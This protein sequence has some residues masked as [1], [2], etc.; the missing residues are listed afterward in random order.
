MRAGRLCAW[1]RSRTQA[2]RRPADDVVHPFLLHGSGCHRA[3]A[4]LTRRPPTFARLSQPRRGENRSGTRDRSAVMSES[5]A[6][7]LRTVLLCRD[8]ADQ[9]YLA[10]ELARAGLLDAVVVESRGDARRAKLLKTFRTA[11]LWAVPLKA[12]DVLALVLYGNWSEK[13]LAQRL[14]VSDYP[15]GIPR[16][17]I[18]DANDPAGVEALTELRPRC[19]RGA[20]NRH[21]PR[22]RVGH[23]D[24][25]RAECPRR[26]AA[27]YRNVYSD[28]WPLATG[29][30]EGVG[31]TIFHLDPGVD[32]G[33]IA[34]AAN[35]PMLPWL[36]FADIKVENSR[37]RARLTIAALEQANDGT[38]PRVPQGVEG[39]RTWYAPSAA[40]LARGLWRIRRNR[41]RATRA[42]ARTPQTAAA[43]RSAS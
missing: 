26:Q 12:L 27:Q 10:A 29:D 31:S 20:R 3:G 22:S 2:S 34:L 23:P 37:L 21:P 43:R 14:G 35:V 18:V 6:T 19:P 9:R 39:A 7:R 32:T 5:R 11:R 8:G 1:L 17:D 16:I 24:E 4:D 33:D 28:F 38:L 13:L 42:A 30:S 25:L 36:P 15:A 40:Q 41:R